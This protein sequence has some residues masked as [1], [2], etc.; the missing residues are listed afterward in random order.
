VLHLLAGRKPGRLDLLKA[1]AE[2]GYGTGVCLEGRPTEVLQQV[3]VLVNA[4]KGGLAGKHL[5]EIGEVVVDKMG[6]WLRW[7]HFVVRAGAPSLGSM[8]AHLAMV[9]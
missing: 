3:I 7:I 2:A 5:M 6:E 9:Q 8:S 1:T 4:V